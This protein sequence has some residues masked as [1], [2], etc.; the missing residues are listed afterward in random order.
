MINV[1]GERHPGQKPRRG[2]PTLHH[3]RRRRSHHRRQHP[4]GLHPVLR[5]DDLALKE[6]WRHHIDFKS[7]LFTD[8][9]KGFRLRFYRLGL[10][11]HGLFDR[12]LGKHLCGHRALFGNLGP[13]VTDQLGR[14][15][16]RIGQLFKFTECELQLRPVQALALP[17]AEELLFEPADLRAQVRV[18][19]LEE[20]DSFV[21]LFYW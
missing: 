19:L 2:V 13:L 14:L 9:L 1:F 8:A 3:P 21:G 18:L 7:P 10:D 15:H 17:A 16:H 4:V 5:A 6:F 12:Q 20:P 11:H